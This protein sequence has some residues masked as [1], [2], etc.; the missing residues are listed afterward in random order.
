MSEYSEKNQKNSQ[1]VSAATQSEQDTPAVSVNADTAGGPRKNISGGELC[2]VKGRIH[3][4]QSL[5]TVD[6]PGVRFVAFAQGCPLRCLYCHNPDTWD[7]SG[8]EETTA[9]DLFDRAVR[10]REY[11]GKRGGVT[12]S[13]GEPLLQPRLVYAWFSLCKNAGIHT[14]LDTS[15]CIAG[16]G[17]ERVLDVTDLVIL[18]YK[19]TDAEAYRRNTR[20]EKEKV[21]AFLRRLEERKKSVWIRQV[22]VG[23]LTDGEENIRELFS[24]KDRYSCIEKIELLPFRK[25]CLEKYRR[26]GIPFPL[27]NTPETS[28]ER[29]R[30]LKKLTEKR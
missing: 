17:T 29:I 16:E 21:D 12:F 24:L 2:A 7:P 11:F 6:G 30:E 19:F 9:G 10:C 22:I 13:G 28:E 3:S 27:E 5:G 14:A 8:G 4:V 25:L 20:C 1:T 15:G 18:D 23:G 26:M